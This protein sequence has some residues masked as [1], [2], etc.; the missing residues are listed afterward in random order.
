MLTQLA[1]GINL[2][3]RETP[4]SGSKSDLVLEQAGDYDR[5]A[6]QDKI[7]ALI[8]ENAIALMTFEECPYCIEAR[9]ILDKKGFEYKVLNLDAVGRDSYSFRA[10][11]YHM[12]GRTSVPAIWIG[13]E[14]VGG[15]ND[16]PMGGLMTMN[17]SGQLDDMVRK[18]S[19]S[20]T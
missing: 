3:M 19:A 4:F 2:Q 5:T 14:F 15:C 9:S 20:S 10:E 8:D 18:A 16:G 17:D 13:G 11:L 12:T 1:N 7:K 6:I